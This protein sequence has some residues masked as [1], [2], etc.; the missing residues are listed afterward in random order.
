MSDLLRKGPHA[1]AERQPPA[2]IEIGRVYLFRPIQPQQ[3]EKLGETEIPSS[4]KSVGCSIISAPSGGKGFVYPF[5]GGPEFV[6]RFNCGHDS[7]RIEARFDP[8]LLAYSEGEIST[9]LA[10]IREK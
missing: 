8:S 2:T 4:L 3:M 6:I 9:A 7:Y 5:I 10:L 1:L